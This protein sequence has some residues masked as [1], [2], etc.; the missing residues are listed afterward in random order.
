M[1]GFESWTIKKAEHWR[2]DAFELWCWK[3][4]LI[5]P[6]TAWKSNQSILKKIN[7][8]Y[9][10]GGLMQK[11]KLRYFGH[12]MQRANSLEILWPSDAGKDWGQ[13]RRAGQQRLEGIIDA[14]D[15]NLSELW[16][17]LKDREAQHAVVHGVTKSWTWLSD[18]TTTRCGRQLCQALGYFPAGQDTVSRASGTLCAVPQCSVKPDSH[19]LMWIASRVTGAKPFTE[20]HSARKSET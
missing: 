10:L 13:G 4:F 18:W 7:P 17:I 16:E 3:R 8:E 2:I 1:Y 19:H 11:L 5:V 15:R 14:M 20:S 9:S 12:L 6:W